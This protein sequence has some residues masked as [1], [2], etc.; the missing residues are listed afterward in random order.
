MTMRVPGIYSD[1]RHK[2]MYW[3]PRDDEAKHCLDVETKSD[4]AAKVF[5]A[6]VVRSVADRMRSLD[7]DY[8]GSAGHIK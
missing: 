7:R 1:C 2:R 6:L 4:D 5:P 3:N 8:A